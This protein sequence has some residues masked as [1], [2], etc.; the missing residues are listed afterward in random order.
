MVSVD[1]VALQ[2]PSHFVVVYDRESAILYA[3]WFLSLRAGMASSETL[4]AA[5]VQKLQVKTETDLEEMVKAG[6]YIYI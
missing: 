2:T 4:A 5:A 3:W 1:A 6:T